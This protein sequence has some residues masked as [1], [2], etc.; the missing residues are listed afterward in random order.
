MQLNQPKMVTWAVALILGVIAL[1][2]QFAMAAGSPWGF[3]LMTVA[4]VVIMASTVLKGL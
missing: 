3:W 4:F 1:I 2:L